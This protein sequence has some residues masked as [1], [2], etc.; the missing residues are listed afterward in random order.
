MKN[1]NSTPVFIV[2][3]IF[4]TNIVSSQD[5]ITTWQTTSGESITIPTFTGETY[6]YTVNWGDGTT[7]PTVYTGNATHTY[8]VTGMQT[9]TI[10]GM[11]P[12]I[13]FND[14][15]DAPKI[16]AIQQWG[17]TQWTSMEFAFLG[18]TNLNILNG[19]GAPN[20]SIT[21]SLFGMFGNCSSLNN[22]LN[23]WDT[24]TIEDMSFVFFGATNF[25]GDISLWN[26]SNALTMEGMF[27]GASNFNQ[28]ISYK[29][30]TNSWDV[31]SV[32]TMDD[33]F[34]TASAF[35]RNIGNWN[36]GNVE[37]M[38]GMFSE[39]STFNQNIGNWNT[40]KVT[41]M[42]SM[43]SEN[44]AFNQNLNN[45]NTALVE[46]MSF[47][48]NEATAFNGDITTWNT[49]VVTNM[50][51]M[52]NKAAAFNQNINYNSVTGSWNTS[53]VSNMNTM[54][55]EATNFDQNIGGWLV[56][57]V[58]SM[59]DMFN[60]VQLSTENYD[61]TLKGWSEQTLQ[62]NVPFHGGTSTYCFGEAANTLII[63]NYDWDVIDGGKNCSDSFISTWKTDNTGTSNDNQITITTAS[64]SGPYNYSV[65]WGDGTCDY[66]ITDT[67]VHT[68]A[69]PGTYTVTLRGQF[70]HMYF[71]NNGDRDKIISIDQWGL[72]SW[73]TMYFAFR[74]CSNLVSNATD[75]PNLS[76]VTSLFSMFFGASLF[77][78]DISNWDVSTIDNMGQMFLNAQQFNQNLSNWN[79]SNVNNMSN[80]FN[81]S[82]LSTA[83][84]DTMLIQWSALTLQND[85]AFGTNS[86]YCSAYAERQNIIDTFNWTIFDG[87]PADTPPT[88]VCQD[89]TVQLDATGNATITADAIEN[90]SFGNC[91]K[92]IASSAINIDTFTCLNIGNNTVT[93][94][95]TDSEGIQGTCTATVTVTA[96]PLPVVYVNSNAMGNNTGESW[97]NA[98]TSLQEALN[99]AQNCGATNEIWVASGTYYPSAVPRDIT[100]L[101][102]STPIPLTDRDFTFHLVNGVKLYGGFNGT[103]TQL[104][105][106]NPSVNVTTLSG[107]IGVLNDTTDNIRHIILSINDNSDTVIDG[108]TITKGNASFVPQN[109]CDSELIIEGL[110]INRFHGPAIYN[111]TSALQ[112]NTVNIIE[113]E[114]EQKASAIYNNNATTS[115]S[116][117]N[118]ELNTKADLSATSNDYGG[119]IHN[120]NTTITINNTTFN[121]NSNFQGGAVYSIGNSNTTIDHCTFNSNLSSHDGGAIYNETG[122]LI[123]TNSLFIQNNTGTNGGAILNKNSALTVTNTYFSANFTNIN[124]ANASSIPRYGGA[125]LLDNTNANIINCG[126]TQNHSER[127]GGAI[128]K[129]SAS[130]AT[131]TNASFFG[132]T[133]LVGNQGP[134]GSAIYTFGNPITLNNSVFYNNNIQLITG[135]LLGTNNYTEE[136]PSEYGSPTGYTQLSSNPFIN[137][138]DLAGADTIY[139]TQDDGLMPANSSVLI[140]AGDNTLNTE[141]NE[142]TGQFRILGSTIDVGAY[143]TA[144]TVSLLPKVFLEGPLLTASNPGLMNDLLRTGGYLPTTSPYLD[145]LTCNATV[146]NTGG[147]SGSGS[148]DKDIV[149]WI[150]VEFRDQNDNTNTIASTS[151]LLQRDGNIVDTDGVSPLSIAIPY[152]N[153]FITIKHRNHLGIMTANTVAINQTTATVDFTDANTPITFG[154]DA[155]TTFGMPINTLGMW[156]GDVNG[157]GQLNYLGAASEI[158][159]IRSQVFNDPNN[160]VFGGPPIGTFPSAGYHLTDINMDGN[161][162]FS[163]VTTDVLIIRNNIFNNPS[164]SV[165][166]GPP[167]GT[168]L[169]I[170]QL[171]E[172]AN[173]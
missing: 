118:I 78:Q 170:Q 37:S 69:T 1:I 58:T 15:A 3:L 148:P 152:N 131:I 79:I 12:R 159:A 162:V 146:F 24:S 124:S 27:L 127:A 49:S 77:N 18:C 113:N 55:K 142:V 51:W 91:G 169:F 149:D 106:R 134:N 81:G 104:N 36:V 107:D 75:T 154:T 147:T 89:I 136:A 82:A 28:D 119:A 102:G 165:F 143:E 160:S 111:E 29:S 155:Q 40:E 140:D 31:S 71:N 117:S 166:G 44:S 14:S 151:A 141:A 114:S 39:A 125:I 164:N 32:N 17:T 33:M 139:G 97:T 64:F 94:T 92:T 73:T 56:G 72:D 99:L 53:L 163:G 65:N 126:F 83:N 22:D 42:S 101:G 63:S 112:M 108:F 25:N 156:A 138:N 23:T 144:T 157:D 122:P 6:S 120:S 2:L 61:R 62:Y 84:Y 98:F 123:I 145:Q 116:N 46:D 100:T 105:E 110:L 16:L 13:Y 90:G 121:S 74:N 48:F 96:F 153:Y 21:T 133:T 103:E 171:P 158:P 67:I 132:N 5:F 85:V 8:N 68:Y 7:D 173:N 93:L 59:Q 45:W 80:M 95:V 76:N 167:I 47:M 66:N 57:N 26:T 70:P 52:F 115:V 11:F 88:V 87:G 20:L 4:I 43:F 35:N 128:Y 150:L 168:Y 172:G 86:K 30:G 161:T 54:F 9:V 130:T 109:C 38:S 135:N 50:E 129:E 19:A 41:D 10:T 137:T 60:G 34:N